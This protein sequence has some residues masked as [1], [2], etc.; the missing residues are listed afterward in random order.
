MPLVGNEY[1][2]TGIDGPSRWSII[3]GPDPATPAGR[4]VRCPA[5]VNPTDADL[6]RNGRAAEGPAAGQRAGDASAATDRNAVALLV[7]DALRP[8]EYRCLTSAAG[9]L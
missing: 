9:A 2:D 3:E 8:S 5:G 7:I 4:A 1:P 6:E